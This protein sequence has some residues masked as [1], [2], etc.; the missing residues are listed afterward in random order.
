M[1]DIALNQSNLYIFC[2]NKSGNFLFCNEKFAEA[3]D[4]DSPSQIVGKNDNELIWRDQANQFQRGDHIVLGGHIF[5]N[6]QEI[7]Y[8][9]HELA[10][11]LVTKQQ[12]FDKNNECNGVIGHFIDISGYHVKKNSGYYDPKN[13]R[14]FLGESFNNRY[15]SEQ[16]YKVFKLILLGYSGQQIAN[17]L[18]ISRR[19]VEGYINIIKEKMHCQT[20]N[21]IFTKAIFANLLFAPHDLLAELNLD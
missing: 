4:L 7:M 5:I 20:K 1:H 18:N 21:E 9:N 11:I 14:F 6:I 13:K 19:T 8:K 3:A 15:L 10:N 2:K 12:Y 16:Q 17:T